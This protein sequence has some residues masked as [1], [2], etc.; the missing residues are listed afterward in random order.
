MLLYKRPEKHSM[1]VHC[2]PLSAH[3]R[4][5][6]LLHLFLVFELQLQRY[7]W[8]VTSGPVELTREPV[9]WKRLSVG[10]K[11]RFDALRLHDL[12]PLVSPLWVF[13]NSV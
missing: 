3:S 9:Q 6:L 13:F 8:R 1:A 12:S 11:D 2:Y 5:L 7:D 4:C 10:Q